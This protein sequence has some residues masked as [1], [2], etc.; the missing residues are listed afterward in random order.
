MSQGKD[1]DMVLSLSVEEVLD[2]RWTFLVAQMVD[3]RL[4]CRRPGFDSWVGKIP[5]RREWKPTPVFLPGKSH[6][7]RSLVGYSP[8]GC[9]ELDTTQ[10]LI[11][12]LSPCFRSDQIRS[13]TQSCPTLCDPMNCSTRPPCPSPTPGVH[14]DSRPLSQ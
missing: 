11:L 12:S 5:W 13:V 4:Q 6:A 10:R 9:E 8:W 14:S 1:T 2:D 7:Q 3:S